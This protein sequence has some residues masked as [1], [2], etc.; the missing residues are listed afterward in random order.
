MKLRFKRMDIEVL[1]IMEAVPNQQLRISLCL[2][3]QTEKQNRII[4]DIFL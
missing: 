2:R 4:M 1:F 3:L